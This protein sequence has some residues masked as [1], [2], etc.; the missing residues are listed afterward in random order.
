VLTGGQT[1]ADRAATDFALESG[2]AYGGWVP[3]GG[4]AEDFPLPPGVLATYP[5]FTAAASGD[6]AERTIRNV[7]DADGLLVVSFGPV[8][9]HGTQL[10]LARAPQRPKPLASIDLQLGDAGE[11]LAKLAASLGP[12][13]TLNVAGPRESEQPGIYAATRQFLDAQRDLLV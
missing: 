1:G 13:C 8:T 4:W 6:P 10:A 11:R 3:R 2:L 9:S 5:G 7:D 12:G